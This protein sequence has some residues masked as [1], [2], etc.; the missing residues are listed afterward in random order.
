MGRPVKFYTDEHVARA[1]VRAL[2]ARGVDVLS[3]PEAGN[4][5][6]PD[7]VHL[8]RARAEG[9]VIF[10]QDAG[11][12]ALAAA[13]PDHAGIAFVP[14][15]TSIGDIVRGLMLIHQVMDAADMLGHVEYL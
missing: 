6:E 14:Q 1:V 11:F 5:E 9:R 15:G 10:T 12:L 7:E 3:V 8:V 2:R 13:E 4:L